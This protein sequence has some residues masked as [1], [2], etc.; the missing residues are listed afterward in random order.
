M[1]V[2]FRITGLPN[3]T[4]QRPGRS[5]RSHPATERERSVAYWQHGQYPCPEGA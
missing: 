3:L 2:L 4:L 5:L 1:T